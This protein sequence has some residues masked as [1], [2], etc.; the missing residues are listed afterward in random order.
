MLYRAALIDDQAGGFGADI[1]QSRA[2]LLVI[3]R[4]RSFGRRQLLQ[5]HVGH[6]QPGTIHRID[7]VLSRGQRYKISLKGELTKSDTDSY[8]EDTYIPINS[9]N[10]TESPMG[11]ELPL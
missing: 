9:R 3:I 2:E 5:D 11:I 10:L 8:L 4:E 6:R 1:H 7:R